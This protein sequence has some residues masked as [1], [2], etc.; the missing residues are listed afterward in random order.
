MTRGVESTAA[1][2]AAREAHGGA[3]LEVN[4]RIALRL[5]DV[6]RVLRSQGAD[7]FR[8]RAYQ[9]A[10]D[11]LRRLNRPIDEIWRQQGLEGLRA[12]P[13]VGDT[14]AHAI[15]DLLT[16]GRLAML[17]RLRGESDPVEVLASVPAIGRVFARRLHEEMGIDTLEELEAAAYD[18]RLQHVAGFGEK[19][20]AA[21]RDSLAQRLGRVR[22]AATNGS[23][24]P[25]AELL[26][27]DREYREKAAAGA[28]P[29]IAPRRMNPTHEAWLPVLHTRRGRR[30][31][32]VLFSNTPRA[33][34]AGKTR[35]WVVLY[36]DSG[37]GER[38]HTVLTASRGTN[39]GKRIVAG[40][41]AECVE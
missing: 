22:P 21:V 27:V 4:A 6:A 11:E 24:V 3:D 40:R 9:R 1:P 13:T 2:A 17:D 41:E 15:R 28:L 18:G 33:H 30:Q 23:K 39:A 20:L 35:D 12:L 5:E 31:Y 26:D 14:I 8:V 36:H 16:H 7:R 37:A 32:T 29:T 10:A 38:Q 34:Q 25:I 19:R